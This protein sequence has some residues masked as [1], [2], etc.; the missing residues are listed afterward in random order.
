MIPFDS[1]DKGF[2]DSYQGCIVAYSQQAFDLLWNTNYSPA[3]GPQQPKVDFSKEMVLA[4]YTGATTGLDYGIA[5]TDVKFAQD[6]LEVIVS[7]SMVD[8]KDVSSLNNRNA[9]HL[10]KV[11][12]SEAEVIFLFGL[13]CVK[14]WASSRR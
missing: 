7:P 4:A 6:S 2:C 10:V 1:L 8:L 14:P 11:P 9:Y 12:R 5:I 13:K 3:K